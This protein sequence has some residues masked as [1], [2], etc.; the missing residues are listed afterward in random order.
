[1]CSS[2]RAYGREEEA[3]RRVA[4]VL[5]PPPLSLPL[6]LSLS[7][8]PPSLSLVTLSTPTHALQWAKTKMSAF[9]SD[10]AQRKAKLK[11]YQRALKK[12]KSA[13]DSARAAQER[14]EE[15]LALA[16]IDARTAGLTAELL[17]TPPSPTA[18]TK[19]VEKPRSKVGAG[20]GIFGAAK[21]H[22]NAPPVGAPPPSWEA[23]DEEDRMSFL[24]ARA[25]ILG[26]DDPAAIEA[27]AQAEEEARVFELAPFARDD[28]NDDDATELFSAEERTFDDHSFAT[29]EGSDAASLISSPSPRRIAFAAAAWTE[30]DETY[31]FDDDT[32]SP[33]DRED[34]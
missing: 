11:K 17:K 3:K 8:S 30:G 23:Q 25:A 13:A 18:S 7:P 15:E 9:E 6:S 28:G 21:M 10:A 20:L 1:M 19:A 2:Q 34:N 16:L 22:R 32:V 24:A 12:H 27:R 5:T 31:G 14:A 4:Y 33:H 26:D 29:E